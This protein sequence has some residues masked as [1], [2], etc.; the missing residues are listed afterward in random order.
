MQ[1]SIIFFVIKREPFELRSVKSFWNKR[2]WL[3]K[4]YAPIS[5]VPE[6]LRSAFAS[7]FI[8]DCL[9][10]TIICKS[11]FYNWNITFTLN[12]WFICKIDSSGKL[13]LK[14]SLAYNICLICFS[15]S[16]VIAHLTP[17]LRFAVYQQQR[18]SN[19]NVSANFSNSLSKPFFLIPCVT[20]SF[21]TAIKLGHNIVY[22][23][24]EAV[25]SQNNLFGLA[26]AGFFEEIQRILLANR[27][28]IILY[29]V[30]C[31]Y[32]TKSL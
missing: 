29:S 14:V 11:I 5:S 18:F 30:K 32:S 25:N 6:T 16:S 27:F 22:G 10:I 26:T 3:S 15:F 28:N 17:L 1:S 21:C 7:K 12:Y 8:C 31:T 20:P 2:K 13:Y 4:L 19:S 9:Y 24:Y 23:N